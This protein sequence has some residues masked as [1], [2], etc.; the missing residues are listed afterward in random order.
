MTCTKMLREI[1][2]LVKTNIL[3]L[4]FRTVFYSFYVLLRQSATTVVASPVV[5]WND[6]I[7]RLATGSWCN[8]TNPAD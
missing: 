6:H 3:I 7:I 5:A 4:R 1:L 8:V 2:P